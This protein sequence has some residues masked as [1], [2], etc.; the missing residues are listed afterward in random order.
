M[1]WR[2]RYNPTQKDL[3]LAIRPFSLKDPTLVA[4]VLSA[5]CKLDPRQLEETSLRAEEGIDEIPDYEK[6]ETLRKIMGVT[7]DIAGRSA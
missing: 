1:M 5:C 7:Q 2:H 3:Q 4:D 6:V